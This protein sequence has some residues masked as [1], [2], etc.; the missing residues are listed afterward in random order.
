MAS[1]RITQRHNNVAGLLEISLNEIQKQVDG[2]KQDIKDVIRRLE[3]R[4]NGKK[5]GR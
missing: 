4:H 3:E 2:L 5:V 1:E